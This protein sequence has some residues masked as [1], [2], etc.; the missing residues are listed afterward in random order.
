MLRLPRIFL[1]LCLSLASMTSSFAQQQSAPSRSDIE[2]ADKA[3][4]WSK[5]LMLGD[6]AKTAA[7]TQLIHDHLKAVRDWHNAHPYTL[8][9]AGINP[10]TG[11]PLSTQDRQI[12]AASSIPRSVH[13]DLINGLKQHL[14][15]TQIEGVLDLYTVGKVAFTLKG[16]KA[17]VPDLTAEEEAFIL[18]ELKQAR[19]T[20]ID[21]KNMRLISA[22]FEI[23]KT[24]CEQYLNSNGRNWKQLYKDYVAAAKAKKAK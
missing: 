1:L 9:P 22:I 10:A 2:I 13:D 23:H 21:F 5:T 17:I 20:A 14:S 24:R 6:D 12:I 4:M 16:Y 18:N 15:P 8:V 19:E 11:A 7:V 3:N